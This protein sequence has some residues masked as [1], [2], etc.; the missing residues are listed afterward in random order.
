MQPV[1]DSVESRLYLFCEKSVVNRNNLVYNKEMEREGS[2]MGGPDMFYLIDQTLEKIDVKGSYKGDRQ[3]VAVL[4]MEQW[5][6]QRDCFDMGIEQDIDLTDIYNTKAEVN[7]DSLTGTFLIPDRTDLCKEDK[8]AFALDEKGI[9][10][11]DES[12][13]V[14]DLIERIV[15]RKRWKL[16]CMER[17]L[18]DF[19]EQIVQ[20]DLRLMENYERELSQL[21]KDISEKGEESDISRVNDIRGDIR[22]LRIH[23]EQLL[24]LSQELEENENGFFKEENLRYFRMI[25]SRM[26][27]LADRSAYLRD[28]TMQLSDTYQMKLESRQN[29]IMTVLTVVS[30]IFM[31]LTLIVGWYGMNFRYMPEL[32]YVY[33]YP[34]VGIFCLS[35]LV[36]GL[37]F[38]KKKKLL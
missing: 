17:F 32:D 27:R 8:F 23:Y 37:L 5:L 3:Y 6:E 26:E 29:R 13:K 21:E 12:G 7:F 33:A 18:S 31:P 10:F 20:D 38:F 16:P 11:I 30:T 1:S 28:Y 19:L 4:S 9:V 24:D 35:I 2:Y 15:Q 22:D 14:K 36:G 34:V 25:T